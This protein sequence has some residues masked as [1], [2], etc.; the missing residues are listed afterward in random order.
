[1]EVS[2]FTKPEITALLAQYVEVRLHVDDPDS[3]EKTKRHLA[4]RN[5]LVQSVALPIYAIVEPDE[6]ETLLKR[7]DGADISGK[8][9]GAFLENYLRKR[10]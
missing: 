2:V 5:R 10:G 4:Y 6:P 1:M 8:R 7:F 9:F 3:P